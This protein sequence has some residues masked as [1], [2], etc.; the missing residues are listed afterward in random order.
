MYWTIGFQPWHQRW[1]IFHL[2][3]SQWKQGPRLCN[4]GCPISK[5]DQV[6]SNRQELVDRLL[7]LC[8]PYYILP[9][10]KTTCSYV[11]TLRAPSEASLIFWQISS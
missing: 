5:G 8:Q 10:L 7:I 2:Q 11:L 3:R 9:W 6:V 1:K 4:Q